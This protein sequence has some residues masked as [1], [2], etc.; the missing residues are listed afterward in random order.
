VPKYEATDAR[1][2]LKLAFI[3]DADRK[4]GEMILRAECHKVR[5]LPFGVDRAKEV[6]G[7]IR[8]EIA[9]LRKAAVLRKEADAAFVCVVDA[10]GELGVFESDVAQVEK[11]LGETVGY[12]DDSGALQ[13]KDA[14]T[15]YYRH[16]DARGVDSEMPDGTVGL[17]IVNM[18]MRRSAVEQAIYRLRGLDAGVHALEF[19]V[20]LDA[21]G[22]VTGAVLA[23]RFAANEAAYIHAAE[24]LKARQ[25]G[26]A[27]S[28][29][30]SAASFEHELAYAAFAGGLQTHTAEQQAE[31]QAVAQHIVN[32]Q[33]LRRCYERD[34]V[35]IAGGGFAEKSS[36][37]GA[38]QVLGIEISQI[39][40]VPSMRTGHQT[41]TL[42]RAFGAGPSG[43]S[44]PSG[45]SGPPGPPGPPGSKTRVVVMTIVEAWARAYKGLVLYTHDGALL[46]MD[47]GS[48]EQGPVLL[49][50]YLCDDGL[51][52][53]EEV[54]LVAY[55]QRVYGKPDETSAL[56]AL[57]VCLRDSGF[58]TKRTLLL[59]KLRTTPIQTIHRDVI[60]DVAGAIE[61][62]VGPS[63]R[64][65]DALCPAGARAPA[66]SG[67]GRR[68]STRKRGASFV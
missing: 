9:R 68:C 44:K 16:R 24:A 20:A 59:E 66:R 14:R 5:A 7:V 31:Q 22:A 30:E 46:R 60:T 33:T 55:A 52:L 35:R 25:G 2:G 21:S 19:V 29:K 56:T 3:P 67:F 54:T 45:P 36:L 18:Q 17:A 48:A 10:S 53:E 37:G 57:V 42:R 1:A 47:G 8:D 64:L 62:A 26:R 61:A 27:V 11:Q 63:R 51:S 49:G 58:L 41:A 38:L 12:F 65:R 32:T 15:R 50:R 40:E 39:L 28:A 6:L 4:A 43:P 23:E 13:N 34:D